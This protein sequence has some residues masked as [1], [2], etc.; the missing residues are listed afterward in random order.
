MDVHTP[1]TGDQVHGNEHGTER[2]ELGQDVVDLVVRVGHLDRDLREVVRVR[3]RENLLVVVQVLVSALS[4][5]ELETYTRHSDQV[6]L[7]I[8]KI[9]A[10]VG[11]RR[12]EPVLIAAL[13]KTLDDIGL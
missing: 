3:T 6:V 4:P 12:D 1:E 13:G 9:E 7:D 10:N 5:Q 8:R 2:S 11:L